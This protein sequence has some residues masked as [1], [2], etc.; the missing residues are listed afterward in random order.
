MQQVTET[1]WTWTRCHR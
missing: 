1:N